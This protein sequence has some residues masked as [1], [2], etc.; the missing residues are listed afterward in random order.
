MT[1]SGGD[2]ATSG[3]PSRDMFMFSCHVLWTFYEDGATS[4]RDRYIYF[5]NCADR[6]MLLSSSPM[7]LL[8]LAVAFATYGPVA[9]ACFDPPR[10]ARIYANI[11]RPPT[12]APSGLWDHI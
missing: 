8:M 5:A 1:R 2:D 6:K 3:R 9:D 12:V 11:S 4:R 10:T 7:V